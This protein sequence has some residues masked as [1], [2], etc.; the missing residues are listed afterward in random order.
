MAREDDRPPG[1]ILRATAESGERRADGDHGEH[2]ARREIEE[3]GAA[4]D[5]V[6]PSEPRPQ[7]GGGAHGRVSSWIFVIVVIAAFLAG[8]IALV[9]DLWWLFWVGVGIVV[10][11]VPAGAAIGIMKDTVQWDVPLDRAYQ[12]QGHVIVGPTPPGRPPE[13]RRGDGGDATGHAR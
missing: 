5:A 1:P 3:R 8:G 13:G 7:P 4:A 6:R 11:S 10:L 12:P 9:V 2:D